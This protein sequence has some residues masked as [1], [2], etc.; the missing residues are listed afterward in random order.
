MSLIYI[1][2]SYLQLKNR[3]MKTRLFAI[4]TFILIIGY[5][6]SGFVSRKSSAIRSVSKYEIEIK[7]K[8]MGY[9]LIGEEATKEMPGLMYIVKDRSGRPI[10]EE[11]IKAAKSLSDIIEYYPSNWIKDYTS[12]EII[13][14]Y[15]GEEIKVVGKNETFT[16]SQRNMFKTI[17]SG[18]EVLI[19][20]NYNTRNPVTN[21]KEKRQIKVTFNV[22][23]EVA[24][25]YV[26]GYDEM[27]TYL[28]DHSL[29]EFS[30]KNLEEL[31]FST[32]LFTVRE[33]GQVDNVRIDKT[34]GYDDIDD[35]LV[36]II[37]EMPKWTAARNA[38]G[39]NVSQEFQFNFGL[40]NVADGC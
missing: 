22:T 27:I 33:N 29:D 21:D 30:K 5:L 28:N 31:Q 40:S 37:T 35:I 15:Q 17:T 6:L 24:A 4:S 19:T 20:V 12:V 39:V 14:K 16:N 32:I 38:K 11:K 9:G 26:G 2:T 36:R 25:E 23:P 1:C 18:D 8:Y 10:T 13:K 7:N 3:F 34:S